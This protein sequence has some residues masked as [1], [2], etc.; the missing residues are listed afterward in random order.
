MYKKSDDEL[1]TNASGDKKSN[2]IDI[3]HRIIDIQRRVI[4]QAVNRAKFSS[5]ENTAL[6]N[7]ST[8]N[9]AYNPYSGTY[10]QLKSNTSN[11][12]QMKVFN[13]NEFKSSVCRANT[14]WEEQN[15]FMLFENENEEQEEQEE[16]QNEDAD[17]VKGSIFNQEDKQSRK[18]EFFGIKKIEENLENDDKKK[19]GEIIS[20]VLT[21]K[22]SDQILDNKN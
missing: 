11:L 8:N 14:Y 6:K 22:E 7:K 16:S 5:I 13:N 12:T 15:N 4:S 19:A 1:S 21:D 3:K 17:M 20:F 10:N 9:N 2:N 18:M